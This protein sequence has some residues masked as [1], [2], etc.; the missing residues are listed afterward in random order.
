MSLRE[1]QI[2]GT[3]RANAKFD[4][5]GSTA[6]E[7]T[8]TRP[9]GTTLT[10]TNP[11]VTAPATPVTD[12]TLGPLNASEYFEYT[13]ASGDIPVGSKGTWEA[14]GV[15]EDGTPKRFPSATATFEVLE[16]C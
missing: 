8:F 10:V 5:S 7:L 6:L 16:G 12:P 1:G 2:G 3:F 15:Y 14:C 9:D 13:T 4:M 11:D